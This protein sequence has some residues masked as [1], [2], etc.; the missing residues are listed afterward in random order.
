[1]DSLYFNKKKLELSVSIYVIYILNNN[2]QK[3]TMIIYFVT[4]SSHF[5]DDI[6]V[7]EKYIFCLFL[8]N[9]KLTSLYIYLSKSMVKQIY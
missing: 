3:S 7:S 9:N 6:H 8:L 2:L 5:N 4:Y 1:M